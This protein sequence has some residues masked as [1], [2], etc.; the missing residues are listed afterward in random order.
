MNNWPRNRGAWVAVLAAVMAVAASPLAG[1]FV[2]R[3]GGTPVAAMLARGQ[4]GFTAAPQ[5]QEP[6]AAEQ[7][8]ASPTGLQVDPPTFDP[9]GGAH[10]AGTAIEIATTTSGATIRYTL[11]CWVGG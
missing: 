5:A 7:T 6:E 3:A 1:A 2:P 9:D 4:V 8:L 11:N 10:A